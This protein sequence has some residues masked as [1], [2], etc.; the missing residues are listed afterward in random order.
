MGV[1]VAV[2]SADVGSG[3]ADSLG[4]GDGN[5]SLGVGDGNVSL[6]VGDGNV[7]LG[8]GDG[9]VLLG[10]GDDGVS[11]CEGV[12]VTSRVCVTCGVGVVVLVGVTV[13]VLVG[14]GVSVGV[15]VGLATVTRTAGEAARFPCRSWAT[16]R[17]EYSPFS[18]SRVVQAARTPSSSAKSW[19]AT[20]C[21]PIG[22]PPTPYC[23]S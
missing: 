10:V 15:G 5:V 7:S 12:S 13:G 20:R 17:R 8:V 6:G 4:A 1:G 11:L 23:T 22:F 14:V 21:Q 18:R 3:V 9:N 19:R 16:T 2:G